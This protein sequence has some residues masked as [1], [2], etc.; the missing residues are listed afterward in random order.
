MKKY[1]ILSLLMFSLSLAACG[2]TPEAGNKEAEATKKAEGNKEGEEIKEDEEIKDEEEITRDAGG[3]SKEATG[4]DNWKEAYREI[5]E[6]WEEDHGKDDNIKYNLVYIDDDDIPELAL[7]GDD[8]GWYCIDLYTYI[9]GES[10]YVVLIDSYEADEEEMYYTSA[11]CEGKNDS[12]IEKGNMYF[13]SGGQM[14]S[15]YTIGYKKDGTDYA[16][17]FR[18]DYIDLSW[19]EDAKDPF[20]YELTYIDSEGNEVKVK[21]SVDEDE[22]LYSPDSIPEAKDLEKEFGF[23]FKDRVDMSEG[24][25]SFDE[26]MDI[27]TSE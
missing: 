16:E 13:K 20:S 5:V 1:L 10:A 12:Y 25:L 17:C 7:F 27:L 11:G 9:D 19:S 8:S 2:G 26:I 23:S 4:D 15:Q 18:Y 6:I 21:K 3:I 14:G 24:A 22:D